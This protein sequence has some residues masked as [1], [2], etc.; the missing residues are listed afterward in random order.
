M[1]EAI[2]IDIGTSYTRVACH[3]G[4]PNLSQIDVIE[5]ADGKFDTP[6]VV[7]NLD[8]NLVAGRAAF[9]CSQNNKDSALFNIKTLLS[10]TPDELVSQAEEIK[11]FTRNDSIKITRS[12]ITLNNKTFTPSQFLTELLKIHVN[13]LKIKSKSPQ[14]V[15]ITVPADF[16]ANARQLI[17]ESAK[18]AGFPISKITIVN[19][20]TAAVVNYQNTFKT[21]DG[22]YLVV[23]CAA[24]SCTVT[25]VRVRGSD[26]TTEGMA[27]LEGNSGEAIN[28]AIHKKVMKQFQSN[29]IDQI[30]R[31]NQAM[32]LIYTSIE[33]AKVL[34]SSTERLDIVASVPK[35]RSI[36]MSMSMEQLQLEIDDIL[37]NLEQPINDLLEKADIDDPE[38]QINY[39]VLSGGT[40]AL[41]AFKEKILDA[42]QKDPDDVKFFDNP[43][44]AVAVGAALIDERLLKRNS[45][46]D[47][48]VGIK[49]IIS[50]IEVQEFLKNPL[51]VRVSDGGNSYSIKQVV[52]SGL[53]IPQ[54]KAFV[55]KTVK[56]HQAEATLIVSAYTNREWKEKGT[57][58]LSNLP[59][60]ESVLLRLVFSLQP[61]NHIIV[62]GSVK[63]NPVKTKIEFTL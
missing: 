10:K 39:L 45:F 42:C 36:S 50:T 44:S 37:N 17:K 57:I 15:T 20:S 49:P 60:Q 28:Q 13:S 40:T 58:K 8:G 43:S 6:S 7:A 51:G 32:S 26:Y 24:V 35:S 52:N 59:D 27:I 21:G 48:T 46:R 11:K 16:S 31:N 54:K 14:R 12:G 23:D 56:P 53:L 63:G 41:K 25:L 34:C 29:E 62:E 9:I 61:N 33:D 30:K 18:N 55:F 38:T 3:T 4:N 2:G 22:L 1:E 5:N 19:E 47:V